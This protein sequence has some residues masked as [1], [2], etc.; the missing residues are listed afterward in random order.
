M[1]D[2]KTKMVEHRRA[3]SNIEVENTYLK[4]QMELMRAQTAENKQL[5][6]NLLA[7]IDRKKLYSNIF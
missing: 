4:Q 5:Y 7:A 3:E 2:H 1:K 6:N